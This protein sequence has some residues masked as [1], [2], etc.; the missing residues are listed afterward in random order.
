LN[1]KS[2][3]L[4]EDD[5]KYIGIM[6]DTVGFFERLTLYDN[7]LFFAKYHQRTEQELNDLLEMLE[8]RDARQTRAE[9]LSTGMRQRMLLIR[10]MLHHPKILF[11]DEPTS[12]LDP[13]LSLKVHAL[14]KQ[15][16]DEGTTIFLTTHNMTEATKLCDS[17]S[18]LYNG[19]IV[20][21]GSPQDIIARYSDGDKVRLTFSNG[22]VKVVPKEEVAD[23]SMAD[24]T[25][26]Q[27][28]EVSLEDVFLE[29]TG[30]KLDA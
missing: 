11:L 9:K 22:N 28:L 14:I 30:A 16:R 19:K 29:L 2:Q 26:I 12:G 23:F 24:I 1:K 17:L 8:L 3:E 18:L 21:S 25:K 4:R 13:S 10:A 5:M 20:E 15:L 6:S 7:L 27:S